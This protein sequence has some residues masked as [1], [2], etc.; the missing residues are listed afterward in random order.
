MANTIALVDDD[1]NIL[2]SVAMALEAEGL[3]QALSF[4]T[5]DTIEAILAFVQKRDPRFEGR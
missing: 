5:R 2:T 3:A 1:R 4:Q